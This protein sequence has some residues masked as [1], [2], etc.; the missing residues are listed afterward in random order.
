MLASILWD[1]VKAALSRQG[2]GKAEAK[3]LVATINEEGRVVH[4]VSG[5]TSDPEFIKD[6]VRR[7]S[8]SA[9]TLPG[10]DEST[11]NQARVV[12]DSSYYRLCQP[13]YLCTTTTSRV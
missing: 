9:Y 1:A 11:M 4:V 6:L 10:G 13:E 7:A 8:E 3:F 5:S 2:R 12:T